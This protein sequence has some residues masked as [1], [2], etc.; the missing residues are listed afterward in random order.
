MIATQNGY[1]FR[2]EMINHEDTKNTKRTKLLLFFP[3]V[4]F[5][6]RG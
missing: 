4:F 2:G 1:E 5:V 3:F 6:F